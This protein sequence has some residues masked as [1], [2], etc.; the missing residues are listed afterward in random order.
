MFYALCIETYGRIGSDFEAF[1]KMVV[2]RAG[3]GDT[4]DRTGFKLYWI[5]RMSLALLRG[6]ARLVERF[7][8]NVTRQWGTGF[9]PGDK[10]V[11]V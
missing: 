2:E 1:I 4:V 3:L 9:T 8:G 10:I 7:I 11:V 5:R 6:N